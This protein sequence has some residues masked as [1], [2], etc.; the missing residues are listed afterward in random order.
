MQNAI[1]VGRA[2]MEKNKK[3]RKGEEIAQKTD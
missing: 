2:A 1:V 3:E